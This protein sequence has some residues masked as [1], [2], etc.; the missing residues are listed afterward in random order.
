MTKGQ[1]KKL[2]FERQLHEILDEKAVYLSKGESLCL[3][4]EPAG[5]LGG[6]EGEFARRQKV[7]GALAVILQA[8][9]A[10]SPNCVTRALKI[11]LRMIMDM[12]LGYNTFA[13]YVKGEV[14]F[15]SFV[16]YI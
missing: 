8:G 11:K 9:T 15:V 13:I 12:T 16:N 6:A 1:A 2:E 10:P 3:T 7:V 5:W 4:V 14:L